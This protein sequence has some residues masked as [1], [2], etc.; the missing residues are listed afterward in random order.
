MCVSGRRDGSIRVAKWEPE[1]EKELADYNVHVRELEEELVVEE[2]V[3][4]EVPA[5]VRSLGRST[6]TIGIELSRP[7]FN[8]SSANSLIK[9]SQHAALEEEITC[10]R[11]ALKDEKKETTLLSEALRQYHLIIYFY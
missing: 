9:Q 6:P 7:I 8:S 1:L 3:V 11:N 10:L 5:Q 2:V 4:Q